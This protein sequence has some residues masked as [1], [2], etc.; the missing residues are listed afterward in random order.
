MSEKLI[1]HFQD[2]YGFAK[3]IGDA[4]PFLVLVLF[5]TLPDLSAPVGIDDR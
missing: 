3:F 4:P 2:A 1:R 5:M